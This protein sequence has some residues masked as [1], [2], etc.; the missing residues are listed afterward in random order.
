LRELA[1]MRRAKLRE[2]WEPHSVMIAMNYNKNRPK[3]KSAI[4]PDKINPYKEK[5]KKEKPIVDNKL[6]FQVLKSNFYDNKTKGK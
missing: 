6:F 1:I 2:F 3:G 5:P 4:D